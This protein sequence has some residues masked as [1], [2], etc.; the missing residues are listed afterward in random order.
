ME[1][2]HG[3]C[4]Y[5]HV[6]LVDGIF[7]QAVYMSPY[8]SVLTVVLAYLFA[9][10]MLFVDYA[11]IRNLLLVNIISIDELVSCQLYMIRWEQIHNTLALNIRR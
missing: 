8:L 10:E 4:T 3:L 2:I 11:D 9:L 7:A 5:E 1:H 6:A